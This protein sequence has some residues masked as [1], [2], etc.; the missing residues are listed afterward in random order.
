MHSNDVRRR[1]R[2]RSSAIAGLALALV[3]VVATA[4]QGSN[5]ERPAADVH[6]SQGFWANTARPAPV[7]G[8][9]T[10]VHATR[11][12]PLTLD[13]GALRSALA[14]APRERTDAQ[15]LVIS[16]PAPDGKFQR[17]ALRESA[18]MSPGLARLHPDIKTYSGRGITDPS[19]TIHADLSPIGFHASVR[20]ATGAWYIDP[21]YVCRTP[22]A[23]ASYYGRDATKANRAF[24]ERRPVPTKLL[25]VPSGPFSTGEQLRTYRLALI[26]D[27]GY[28]TYHGGPPNVTP[29]KVALMNRV[30]QVYEDDLTIRLQLVANNDLLNFNTWAQGSAPNGPCGA[31][32][33]FTQSQLTGCTSITRARY[34]IG[35]II[36]ASNYDIGHLGL[37]QPG[38]GVAGGGVGLSGK[39]N[40]CT[41]VPTPIG[42]FFA[43]DYVAHEM[44]HQFTGSHT[45]NGNQ[46]NCSGGN[47]SATNSVEPGSGQSIMAYAGICLT[48]D[49]QPHSDGYFSQRSQQQI[50]AYV[51]SN[52]L[53][54]NEVQTVSLRHFG[55][56]NETQV[57]TF[58]TG[59]AKTA[60]VTPLNVTINAPP[61]A[62]SRG[63]AE[64]VGT[65][66]T[67]ATGTP[68]TL[69]VG[70]TVTVAGVG[71]PGYN[72]TWTVT[73]V[74]S[75]RS[76]QY[77]NPVS[78]LPVSG[79][80]TATPA[81]PG[82][83]SSGTTAT[84]H[85]STPHG[86]AVGDVVVVSG[87]AN[88]AYN[89]TF[90]I[91]AVPT[92]KTFEYTIGAQQPNSGS[93]TATYYSPFKVRIGGNDSALIGGTGL[94][95][96]DAN[97]TSAINAIPGFAGTVT[98]TGASAPGFTVAYSGASAGTDVP[99]IQLV[100]LNCGGCFSSVEETNHGGT[101]DSFRLNYDGALSAPIVNG[102]N[103][104][105]AGIT[106]ALTPILP[107]GATVTV[108]GFGGLT[109]N[110]TGFQ[111]T[112]GGTL[113]L[114][115]VPVL[116]GVQDFTSGASGF[117]GET[118]K[119]G[120]VDNQGTITATGNHPPVLT[121]PGPA[122][123]P[124]RTP[125][126]LT[127]SA[128]DEDGDTIY[129]SWEQNDS[130]GAAGTS[131]L[132]NTKTNGPL[133]AM[134]PLSAP[135]TEEDTLLYNS[136]HENHVTT[137]PTR[138][139]PDLDQVLANNTNAD[140][141]AC[142]AGPIAP[143]APIPARECFGEFLPTSDYTPTALHFRA[144]A[145]DLRAGGGGNTSG[146]VTLTLAA[147]AGP[148]LVT[149]PNTQVTWPP[150][151]QQ[152][153]T[154]DKANTDIPPTSTANVKISLST[155]GGLT[156]PHVLAAST[157]ND[158]TEAVLVPNAPTTTARV[159]IEAVGNIFFDVSNVNFTI[160]TGGPPPPPPPPPP[161]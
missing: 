113:A 115:N 120:A 36:G 22:S 144:T 25:P 105:T 117:T 62:T 125:F 4:A 66:V 110:N 70:E 112:F 139:F 90:T 133:F 106:T 30:D 142:T 158:G 99:N 95:Y 17:F 10:A 89:G 67:I 157:P 91:T 42:D 93:G 94:P 156:Y 84:I 63:G 116:L 109:F 121:V 152:N 77:E 83:S 102:T 137:S 2:R 76:F 149:S 81:I 1:L 34:V 45:F 23:Y 74:P 47:R 134:F 118:D 3:L 49:E 32:A 87:V 59:Y 40:G 69:Q 96:T 50:T 72:G 136:P 140:T 86:R 37:G 26:T 60:S 18:I 53:P 19:A 130:G 138:V 14:S 132:N 15:P 16:L 52:Q 111:V 145:R 28:A 107:A 7:S 78:G 46:L 48:D 114:T 98:V 71:N 20:S 31:A 161:R 150:G 151:S 75:T 160:G 27:P 88:G 8:V 55:G 141:G 61:S 108:A 41:G 92:T 131:L 9:R 13:A 82:A 155:D 33:C 101:F 154:W 159:K 148:F 147:N 119:G 97:L 73:A 12:R 135:V 127:A 122:T 128:T 68:H 57:V 146:D 64:E 79:S 126:A 85:T 5:Q 24:V 29:A 58:G 103:Y 39:A 65:T 100:E 129:Y 124:L 38:G 153:V 104:S 143:P 6:G 54:I 21:Y 80:G 44:G 43:I 56:G 35:Q 51:S 123:I 11:F